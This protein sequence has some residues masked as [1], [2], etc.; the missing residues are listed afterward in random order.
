[1][2]RR[3]LIFA[4][5]AIVLLA[6]AFALPIEAWLGQLLAW[7]ETQRQIAWLVFIASYIAA[8]VLLLPGL[9]LTL[10][11]GALFGLVQGV[12]LVSVASV[13]GAT[14]A[15]L[16]GRTFARE[17][18]RDKAQALPRFALLDRAVEQKGFLIVL[19]TRLSPLF[20]FNLLNY[21]YGLTS[22]RL[23]DYIAAS[24]IG[25]LPGTVLYVYLGSVAGSLAQVARGD[26]SAGSGGRILFIIGL[27]ATVAVAV[28][29]TRL[30]RRALD[31]ELEGS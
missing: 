4:L 8:C 12:I 10:A 6:G 14:A 5:A 22:V 3:A 25:M 17:W 27:V 15:F 11:A 26:V 31:R 20:P 21:A 16:I 30:A 18:A 28:L 7:I 9:I 1:M 13:A 29:V 2:N 19:L 24:W 23:R